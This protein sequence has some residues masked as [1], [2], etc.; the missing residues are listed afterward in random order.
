MLELHST[1]ALL[2]TYLSVTVYITMT[3]YL[4]FDVMGNLN[5]KH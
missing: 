2:P 4:N 5:A 3:V 1:R